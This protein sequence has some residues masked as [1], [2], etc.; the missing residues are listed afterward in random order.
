M[1]VVA[2]VVRQLV[3]TEA[4]VAAPVTRIDEGGKRVDVRT[5]Y[6]A[7]YD[8]VGMKNWQRRLFEGV[9]VDA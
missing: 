6:T 9:N 5:A 3:R 1:L 2:E 8:H 7:S 4:E